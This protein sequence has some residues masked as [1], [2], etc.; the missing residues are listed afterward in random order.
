MI[1]SI[2]QNLLA[3]FCVIFVC[4]PME[5]YW[6]FSITTGTCI[7]I[8]AYFLANAC[9]NAATDI[10]LLILPLFLVKD[11]RLPLLRKIGVALLLMTG[12][13]YVAHC[14]QPSTPYAKHPSVSAWS[15]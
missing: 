8:T 9:I 3:G 1:A 11:Y 7:N 12:S 6:D 14:C 10:A 13:L 2:I 4:Q 5:K 15:V